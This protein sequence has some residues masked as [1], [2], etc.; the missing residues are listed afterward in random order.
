MEGVDRNGFR[1]RTSFNLLH[2]ED[3]IDCYIGLTV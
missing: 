3:R 1:D 2:S